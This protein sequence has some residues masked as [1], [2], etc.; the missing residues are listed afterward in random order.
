M[1]SVSLATAADAPAIARLRTAAADLLTRQ[2]G[3]GHWS[4]VTT[5]QDVLRGILTSRVLI[6][7][8]A[9]EIVATL[10]LATK[11]PWAIDVQYFA[12]V[13]RALYLLDMAVAPPM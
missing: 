7:R 1:L 3:T 13:P 2:H 4:G 10:R 12:V 5:E 8:H 6:A 9:G 11:K